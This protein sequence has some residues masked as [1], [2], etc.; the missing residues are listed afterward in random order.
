MTTLYRTTN[1]IIDAHEWHAAVLLNHGRVSL[2]YKWRPLSSKAYRWS[3]MGQWEGPKPKDFSNRFA[4]F[5]NHIRKAWGTEA[6]RREAL[7]RLPK[8]S[9]GAMTRNVAA[10]AER[11][12]T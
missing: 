11:V 12:A 10:E 2:V 4:M 7:T 6:E 5:R 3:T 1:L 8:V 9:T